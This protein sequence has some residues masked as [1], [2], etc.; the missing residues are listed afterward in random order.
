MRSLQ[1]L[2]RMQRIEPDNAARSC[3]RVVARAGRCG[4]RTGRTGGALALG[5]RGTPARHYTRR[6]NTC[7]TASRVVLYGLPRTDAD[8]DGL[9]RTNTDISGQI[10]QRKNKVMGVKPSPVAA[11]PVY[12]FP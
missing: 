6:N 4:A 10:R 3:G 1:A 8:S 11:Q 5:R 2:R 9:M 12:P 7:Q